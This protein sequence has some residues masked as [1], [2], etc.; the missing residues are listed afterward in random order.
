MS[1][2]LHRTT[3]TIGMPIKDKPK[4]LAAQREWYARNNARAGAK[5]AAYKGR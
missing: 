5:V 4:K 3:R 1:R 2:V